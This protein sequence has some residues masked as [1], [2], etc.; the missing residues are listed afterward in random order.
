MRAVTFQ[1]PG[2]VQLD[3]VAEPELLA[4]DDAIVRVEASGICGSHPHNLPGRVQLAARVAIGPEVGGEVI[5]AGDEVSSVR[6]GTASSGP[7]GRPAGSASSATARS[8]TS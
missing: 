3:D 4:A 5:A 8:S 7:T 1:A 6:S 2:E